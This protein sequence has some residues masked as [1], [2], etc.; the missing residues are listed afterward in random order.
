MQTNKK[1][2]AFRPNGKNG[3]AWDRERQYANEKILSISFLHLI[4]NVSI[5][6]ISSFSVCSVC[7]PRSESNDKKN[8]RISIN[9]EPKIKEKNG[10][11][12]A[13]M[14][15]SHLHKI[16]SFVYWNGSTWGIKGLCS[17]KMMKKKIETNTCR[18]TFTSGE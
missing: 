12:F 13:F 3:K 4:Q 11:I 14:E 17:T 7:Q 15:N 8:H 9:K 5:Y 1:K 2:S 16:N 10:K 6:R 18:Q